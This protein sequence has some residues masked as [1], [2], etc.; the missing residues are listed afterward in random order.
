MDLKNKIEEEHLSY[1]SMCQSTKRKAGQIKKEKQET[2]S[3]YSSVSSHP[4]F[5]NKNCGVQRAEPVCDLFF[6]E[7]RNTGRV[8]LI[9]PLISK[10]LW[11][12]LAS[13]SNSSNYIFL[14]LCHS[15]KLSEYS[16]MNWTNRIHLV[17]HSISCSKDQSSWITHTWPAS[18]LRVQHQSMHL[19]LWEQSEV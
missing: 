16:S 10:A 12:H 4:T 14:I 7:W 2:K 15:A 18:S 1:S 11:V 9:Q 8:W 6:Q 17:F 3:T 5:Q 19:P 13:N